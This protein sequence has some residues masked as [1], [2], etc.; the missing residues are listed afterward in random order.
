MLFREHSTAALKVAPRKHSQPTSRGFISQSPAE[1]SYATSEAKLTLGVSRALVRLHTAHG[2][3]LPVTQTLC[4]QPGP[5]AAGAAL[6]A[7]KPILELFIFLAFAQA[8]KK[9]PRN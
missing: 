6:D 2:K 1:R 5:S 4:S 9:P 8:F 7:G 3:P